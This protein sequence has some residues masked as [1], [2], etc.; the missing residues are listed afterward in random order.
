VR[1][2]GYSQD[3]AVNRPDFLA[4]KRR[5]V[6][7]AEGGVTRLHLAVT[8]GYDASVLDL[9]LLRMDHSVPQAAGGG[10]LGAPGC[11]DVRR[12]DRLALQWEG[13]GEANGRRVEQQHSDR[14][15]RQPETQEP[16][17]S[18]QTRTSLPL[19]CEV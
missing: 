9:I 10:R 5:L 8:R 6:N 17:L 11:L 12:A 2:I 4:A 19:A 14:I 18:W 13:K 1:V 16:G 3:L 7:A 15:A